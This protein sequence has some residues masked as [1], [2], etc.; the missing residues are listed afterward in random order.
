M[1]TGE[2]ARYGGLLALS[3][4]LAVFELFFL[5]LRLDGRVLPDV[6]AIEFPITALLAA[7]T[8]PWLV[9]RAAKIKAKPSFAGGPLYVWLATLLVFLVAGPGGDVILIDDWRTLL[10]MAAGAFP[11]TIKVGGVLAK[12]A[13]G[14]DSERGGH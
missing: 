13:A 7:V 1:T 2:R 4:V 6:G 5:P 14:G 8:L 11:A 12:S 10:L 9:G 3:V